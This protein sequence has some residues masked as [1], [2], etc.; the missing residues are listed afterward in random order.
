MSDNFFK[1]K[2]GLN[3]DPTD[4][5]S[6]S[7]PELG[8][9]IIDSSDNN[10]L[11]KHNGTAF[12]N[13]VTKEDLSLQNVDNTSD[14][15][16]P[17]STAT[18]TALNT[19]VNSSG[20]TLTNGSIVTP[21]RL[22]TKQDTYANLVTYA[23]T[24]SNG[25]LVFATDT[26]EMYQVVDGFLKSVGGGAGGIN[27]IDN[28]E[29]ENNTTGWAT[30]KDA[31][32]DSPA[33]GTGGIAN[34]TFTR[35]T[36]T[37][38]RGNAS[39]LIT[40]SSGASRQGEG[41]SYDFTI[42]AA[43]KAQVLRISFDYNTEVSTTDYLDGNIRV[44]VYDVTNSRLIEVIDRDLYASS[45]GKF[46]GTFQTSSD[47]VSYRLIFHIT[48]T[49]TTT[50]Y[51]VEID[52]VI[53]GP[54]TIVKGAI[55]TDWE[56]FTPSFNENTNVT[57]TGFQRRVG[58]DLEMT[59]R[60]NYTGAGASASL[61]MTLPDNLTIDVNK[62]AS[63][64]DAVHLLS[65]NGSFYDASAAAANNVFLI[66][67]MRAS[68]TNGFRIVVFT[69]DDWKQYNPAS[70]PVVPANG[71]SFVLT[72]KLPIQGWSSN[73]T[74]SEDAGN[75]EVVFLATDVA[76]TL[77]SAS[78]AYND[79][80]FTV[81]QKDTTASYAVAGYTIPETGEYDITLGC[82]VT[83]GTAPAAGNDLNVGIK[84][85]SADYRNTG[86]KTTGTTTQYYPSG[87][88]TVSLT[89]GDLVTP[90]FRKQGN[91]TLTFLSPSDDRFQYFTIAKRS[92]PQTIAASEVVHV[93]A[94]NSSAQLIPNTTSTVITL[95]TKNR[96]THNSFNATTGVFTAPKSGVYDISFG[97]RIIFPASAFF[98]CNAEITI[99]SNLYLFQS[100]PASQ[101]G[102]T[103]T[104]QIGAASIKASIY[105]QKN[106]VLSV[107]AFQASTT[108]DDNLDTTGNYLTIVSR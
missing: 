15:D 1:I 46:V 18:Q 75:R 43:D 50:A 7:N 61:V 95:W 37:P 104:F 53:V 98:R 90:Y 82:A 81:T 87:R 86:H 20:G 100:F 14:A 26:K 44:Y 84:L 32:A 23:T 63:N 99:D 68:V 19:K 45:F 22:D 77:S 101:A 66:G 5:G 13:A 48:D 79:L 70:V 25:Q 9:L 97:Y 71:D 62:L 57:Y 54:Q 8:D 108:G 80:N 92:S 40:K 60:A 56:S 65:S 88:W 42:D 27:Y 83:Y 24:A 49:S 35:T 51:T 21:S 78:F 34:T 47:S 3:I 33:D 29:F 41:V 72:V 10:K 55:V 16:K 6:V 36:S 105:M 107:R 59:I 91:E 31:A 64:L 30:Y 12:V 2:K 28:G 106:Q 11:K 96:D 39:G 102:T 94:I 67:A 69:A 74:L 76:G 38:L 89:K 85:N 58:S 73:V 4:A 93:E 17:I 103:A 52:N